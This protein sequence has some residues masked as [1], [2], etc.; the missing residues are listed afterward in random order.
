MCTLLFG[1]LC[2]TFH[3]ECAKW[4]EQKLCGLYKK[5]A[6]SY[7]WLLAEA[8]NKQLMEFE[9]K[10]MAIKA[11]KTLRDINWYGIGKSIVYC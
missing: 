2:F 10:R 8:N 6:H 7:Y 9:E 1:I 3:T 4:C 11:Q 5:A